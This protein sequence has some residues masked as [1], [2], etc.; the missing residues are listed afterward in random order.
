MKW[1]IC[2]FFFTQM[3]CAAS[4]YPFDTSTQE[5]Q[6][7]H[8]LKEFRCLV[9]QNQDIADSNAELARDLRGQVYKMVLQGK[10]DTEIRDY[11]SYRFGDFILFKPPIKALTWMLW[12]GPFLFLFLGFCVVYRQFA[13]TKVPTT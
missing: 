3:V 6:F 11:L 12:F 8:L 2:L 1:I 5:A 9:C 13:G 10:S 4:F 7:H